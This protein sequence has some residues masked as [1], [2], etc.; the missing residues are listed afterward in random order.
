MAE[1]AFA[2]V[3]IELGVFKMTKMAGGLGNLEFL[4]LG[5]VLVTGSAVHLLA[6]D[7]LFFVEMRF[8]H[9]EN[10]FGKFNLFGLEII[11]CLS[12]TVGGHATGIDDSRPGHNRLAT[13]LEIGESIGRLFGNVFD[14]CYGA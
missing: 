4:F 13:K 11:I 6:F 8:M 14:F 2:P 1:F 3:L 12:V 7:L 5:L 9:K 10:L